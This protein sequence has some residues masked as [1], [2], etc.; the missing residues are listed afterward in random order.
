MRT[1]FLLPLWGWAVAMTALTSCGNDG[2]QETRESY[3]VADM[4]SVSG[5]RI[6]LLSVWGIGQQRQTVLAVDTVYY[7]EDGVL[8]D[9]L[10]YHPALADSL[11][12]SESSPTN[13]S[14]ILS[15]DTTITRLRMQFM[16]TIDTTHVQVEDT[17]TLTYESHPYF[18]DMECGCSIFFT[19]QSLETTTH[20]VRSALI[21]RNDIT[22]EADIN[23]VIEY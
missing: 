23:L 7:V 10:A 11:M 8:L 21:K 3:C 22:N 4:R 9:S 6:T 1:R 2:C 12:I 18:I 5:A 16:A 14:L 15:P 19:L 20:F 13:I 17:L